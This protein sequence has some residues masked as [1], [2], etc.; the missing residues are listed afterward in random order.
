LR[1]LT[2]S[3]LFPSTSRPNFGIFVERQTAA[4]TAVP[5]F[6]VT[7]INPI[8]VAPWPLSL[9]QEQAPPRGFTIEEQWGELDVYR[10][11]F[12]AIPKIGGQWNPRMIASAALPLAKKL[13]AEIGFDVIDAEFFYPDGPA[14]MRIAG[15]LGLPFTIKARGADIHYWGSQPGCTPQ[16]LEAADK[17]AGLLAVSHALKADMVALGIDAAKIMV[18]YT[19]LDKSRFAPRNRAAEK[20]KLGISGSL[21]LSVGALIPRKRQDLLIAALPALPDAT[22]MLAGRG[23]SESDYRA[24]ADRSGVADRV[25]FLGSIAHDDLPALFAAADVMALVSSSEGLANAWVESLACGTPI[26]ASD[27]GGIRELVKTREAGR[28]VAQTPEAVA[29]AIADILANPPSREAVAVNVSAFSW[30]ENAKQ[31]A[32]F[33]R[34]VVAP[35]TVPSLTSQ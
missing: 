10:P 12:T 24:L 1:I 20:A 7:V 18:H 26:V 35:G 16:I 13:H 31:L 25:R 30:D 9:L 8:G 11:R 23:E 22:L 15:A 4:L 34:K 5:D 19:G 21:I 33:F 29:A 28:I 2:L 32:A 17:A 6:A 14:A 27:V 3:T